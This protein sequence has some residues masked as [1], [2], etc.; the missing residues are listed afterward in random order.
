MLRALGL[1]HGTEGGRQSGPCKCARTWS[2]W[3]A[4]LQGMVRW[5][6]CAAQVDRC[7]MGRSCARAFLDSSCVDPERH[8][9][10]ITTSSSTCTEFFGTGGEM[11]QFMLVNALLCH[12]GMKHIF[13]NP[14]FFFAD[15]D[16]VCGAC[17][18]NFRGRL[19]LL[20]LLSVSR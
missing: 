18:T 7:T 20:D 19:R 5:T 4:R 14:M 8:A 2:H 1:E 13:R 6:S 3:L 10:T 12:Q 16:G 17:G 11:R 9:D 15:E